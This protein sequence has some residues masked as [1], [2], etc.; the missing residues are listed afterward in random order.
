MLLILYPSPTA[1]N[2]QHRNS[3]LVWNNQTFQHL[4]PIILRAFPSPLH[5]H[6]LRHYST[7]FTMSGA[8]VY[9]MP[10]S[11][12]RGSNRNLRSHVNT[13]FKSEASMYGSD[14]EDGEG[15]DEDDFVGM[16]NQQGFQGS[17]HASG[18][19]ASR[20]MERTA[21]PSRS[22]K[23]SFPLALRIAWK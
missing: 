11:Q 19:A 5:T 4:L 10:S 14:D 2:H 22:S 17:S 21:G 8:A 20:K 15:E 9:D 1:R 23:V 6:Q 18:S 16:M 12:A 3:T 13:T 7:T